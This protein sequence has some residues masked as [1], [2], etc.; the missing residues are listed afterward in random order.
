M[1]VHEL[2]VEN[3]NLEDSLLQ[4]QSSTHSVCIPFKHLSV[5]ISNVELDPK[6]RFR[7]KCHFRCATKVYYRCRLLPINRRQSHQNFLFCTKTFKTLILS[8]TVYVSNCQSLKSLHNI[9][10]AT[11]CCKMSMQRIFISMDRQKGDVLC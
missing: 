4:S 11:P 10:V 5:M 8:T 3:R 6:S 9:Q 2:Q 1:R 7:V